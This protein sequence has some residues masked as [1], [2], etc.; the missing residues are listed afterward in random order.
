MDTPVHIT[1]V[2]NTML[3][4]NNSNTSNNNSI[5]EELET[6]VNRYVQ[7]ESTSKTNH[8]DIKA[9]YDVTLAISE[10]VL[11]DADKA[12]ALLFTAT[13]FLSISEFQQAED[14]CLALLLFN[15]NADNGAARSLLNEIRLK[16][17]SM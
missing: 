17:N 5:D 14:Y 15:H 16:R 8:K 1:S 11:N 4:S 3:Y 12:E 9:D 13:Y 2:N 7:H 10:H 6:D